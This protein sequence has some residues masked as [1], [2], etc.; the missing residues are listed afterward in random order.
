MRCRLITADAMALIR[1]VGDSTF[2]WVCV[3][4][5]AQEV[6]HTEGQKMSSVCD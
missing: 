1:I 3:R 2:L 5:P 4:G 6:D